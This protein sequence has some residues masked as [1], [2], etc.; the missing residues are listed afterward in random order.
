VAARSGILRRANSSLTDAGDKLG[1]AEAA[2]FLRDDRGELTRRAVDQPVRRERLLHDRQRF[3]PSAVPDVELVAKS[4]EV[5]RFN[6]LDMDA[7]SP[8][9]DGGGPHGQ[10]GK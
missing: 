10:R 9:A 3:L 1:C 8:G 2:A 7:P 6:R 5:A 4:E